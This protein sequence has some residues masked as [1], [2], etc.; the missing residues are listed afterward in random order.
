MGP[1]KSKRSKRSK[2]QTKRMRKTP[3]KT[4]IIGKIYADWCKYCQILK[5]EWEKMK[6]KLRR[7]MGRTLKNAEFEIVEMGDTSENQMRNITV[8]QLVNDF[9]KKH[10]PEG[11]KSIQ[12]DGY[13]TIFR[14]TKKNIEYYKDEKDSEK[15]YKWATKI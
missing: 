1:R 4:I 15:L 3:K 11:D 8:D 9:N 5:P 13:P 10:F 2:R 7:N 12:L 14:I 6:T